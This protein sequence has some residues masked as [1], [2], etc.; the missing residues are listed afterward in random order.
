[1]IA[2]Q[3][4][5]VMVAV[6]GLYMTYL[7]RKRSDFT[8]LE[9]Y[10]WSIIWL[11]LLMV[12]LFPASFALFA[13]ASFGFY[14]TLDLVLVVSVAII[15]IVGFINYAGFSRI[16]KQLEEFVRKEALEQMKK[17]KSQRK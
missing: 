10:S 11:G 15:F 4:L 9:F 13:Q 7:Y 2:L 12:V 16:K 17:E 14:R 1:M 6:V 8:K 3:I 5:G